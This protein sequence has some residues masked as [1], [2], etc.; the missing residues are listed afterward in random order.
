VILTPLEREVLQA[1]LTEFGAAGFPAPDSI[2][3]TAREN[4]GV[5]RFTH[6][7][8]GARISH[9]SPCGLSAKIEVEGLAHGLGA[10]VF[11]ADGQPEML[12]L[13]LWGDDAWDGVERPWKIV[14][15]TEQA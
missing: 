3:V 5:G 8:A 10:L 4:T 12:E 9:E 13:H 7:A 11:L 1:F 6:L 14:P 15:S 2:A